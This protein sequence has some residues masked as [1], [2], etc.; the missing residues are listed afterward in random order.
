MVRY[1]VKE[2]EIRDYCEECG[3]PVP[4]KEEICNEC[5]E[6]IAR[7]SLVI[8]GAVQ[9]QIDEELAAMLTQNVGV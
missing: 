8:N 7:V 3:D 6:E 9:K 5:F 1:W 2:K 4:S